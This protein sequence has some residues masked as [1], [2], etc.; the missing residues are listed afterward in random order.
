MNIAQPSLE[1]RLAVLAAELVLPGL[2]VV[3]DRVIPLALDL[4]AADRNT[5]G[6]V[7]VGAL[8]PGSTMRDAEDSIRR[9]L[10]EQGVELP[11]SVDNEEGQYAAALWA[12]SNGGLSVGEFSRWFYPRLPAVGQQSKMDQELVLLLD[13]WERESDPVLRRAGEARIRKAAA[14][15]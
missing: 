13:E 4:L 14:R 6:T 8:S 9:M 10:A 7:E 11:E 12:F 5:P 3:P 15:A 2:P 1:T